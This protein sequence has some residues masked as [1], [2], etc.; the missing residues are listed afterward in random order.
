[1]HP[2]EAGAPPL[3]HRGR[4][5]VDGDRRRVRGEHGAGG[6]DRVDGRPEGGLDVDILEHRLDHEVGVGGVGEIRGAG[7][8]RQGRVAVIGG[9]PA[10]GHR[11]VQVA[12]DSREARL[13]AG[14]VRLIEGDLLADDRVDLG[15]AVAHEPGARHEDPLDAHARSSGSMWGSVAS[16]ASNRSAAAYGSRS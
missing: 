6:G 2:E 5:P 9:D 11:A 7:E 14:E 16:A 15:D 4:Q 12:G 1:M 3:P 10:L 8:T 13:G